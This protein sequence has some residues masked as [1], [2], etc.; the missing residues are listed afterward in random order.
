[1]ARTKR[2]NRYCVDCSAR[3]VYYARLSNPKAPNEHRVLVYACPNCTKDFEKPKMFSIRR[4][5]VDDPL[6]TVEIEI[7]Q[8]RQKKSNLA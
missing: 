4:N 3:L 6:E 8:Y 5:Q 1:M 7:I 2:T